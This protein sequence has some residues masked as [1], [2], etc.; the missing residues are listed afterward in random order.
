MA[1]HDPLRFTTGTGAKL[2]TRSRHVCTFFGAGTSKACGLPDIAQLQ[3]RVL[4]RLDAGQRTSLAR[5]LEGRNLEQGL[6]RL[7]RI[8]ALLVENQILDGLTAQA[9]VDWIK[10][11][12]EPSSPRSTFA[13]R[14][15]HRVGI[16]QR[17]LRVQIIMPPSKC[18][19]STMTSCSKHR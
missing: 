13:L 8:A 7:R 16:S 4:A 15:S 6:S 18:S 5:Q 2:A 14:T 3:E 17:G 10:P 11:S 12:V 19:R 1:A 9:A